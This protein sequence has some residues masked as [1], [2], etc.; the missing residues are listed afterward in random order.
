MFGHKE[1]LCP[2]VTEGFFSLS[3]FPDSNKSS[4]TQLLKKKKKS[5]KF[6]FLKNPP[7]HRS[8][9]KL[10]EVYSFMKNGYQTKKQL[11]VL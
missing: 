11:K 3:V 4:P 8:C 1:L 6:L 10:I 5:R 2:A 7:K 9:K